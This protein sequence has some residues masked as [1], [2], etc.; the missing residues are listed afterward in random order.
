[1]L[2]V[3]VAYPWSRPPDS[4][5]GQVHIRAEIDPSFIGTK[6]TYRCCTIIDGFN[7]AI[8]SVSDR[9]QQLSIGGSLICHVADRAFDHRQTWSTLIAIQ[10][11]V[12]DHPMLMKLIWI[13]S[14]SY[15]EHIHIII[16]AIDTP[17]MAICNWIR[18][19]VSVFE[20]SIYHQDQSLISLWS[21]ISLIEWWVPYLS[22]RR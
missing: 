4:V 10:S 12:G 15:L 11:M 1:M 6:C 5:T 21:I 20:G 16:I 13:H 18:Y 7:F 17:F 19:L 9:V 22:Y 8:R 2:W 14:I 3:V